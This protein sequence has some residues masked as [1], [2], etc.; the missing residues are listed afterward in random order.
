MNRVFSFQDIPQLEYGNSSYTIFFSSLER[1]LLKYKKECNLDL[2]PE[3]QRSYV[4]ND[5]QK[6]KYVEFL[7]RG[8]RSARD[9][10]FN[11]PRYTKG[12]DFEEV[13]PILN[14]MVI[15]DGKQRLSAIL[16]FMQNEIKAFGYFY[17]DFTGVIRNCKYYLTFNINQL[18]TRQDILNW[19]LDFNSGGTIHTEEELNKVRQLIAKTQVTL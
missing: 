19:Y 12:T 14:R 1:E 5:N 10:Y 17:K 3:F 11:F 18:T 6:E 16:G 2:N 7:L 15:V 8:G 9:I 4:W 13:D